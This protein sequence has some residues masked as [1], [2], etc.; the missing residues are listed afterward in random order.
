MLDLVCLLYSNADSDAVYTGL[1]QDFLV[2]VSGDSEGVK[3]NFGG[4][5][6]FN[7]GDIVSFCCLGCEVGER[8]SGGQ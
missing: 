6:G 3:E 7:L 4:A 1:D 2:F 8:E 5:G